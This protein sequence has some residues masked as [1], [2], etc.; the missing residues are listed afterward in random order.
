MFLLIMNC[1]NASTN[2]TCENNNMQELKEAISTAKLRSKASS[3]QILGCGAAAHFD[4]HD[5]VI[6]NGETLSYSIVHELA[7]RA[8]WGPV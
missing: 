5:A 6:S 2:A 7:S 3:L 4:E 1:I 8:S